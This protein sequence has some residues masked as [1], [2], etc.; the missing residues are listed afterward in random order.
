MKILIAPDSFKGS[1]TALEAAE[2]IRE[3]WM[4]QRPGDELLLAPMADGGEGTVETVLKAGGRERLTTVAGPLGQPVEALW[5][6]LA[7]GRAVIE[8]AAASGLLLVPP[9]ERNPLKTTTYG[10]GELIRAALEEGAHEI[11]LGIGGSATNDGGIGMAQALGFRFIGKD[12]SPLRRP[13]TGAG[14]HEIERIDD[15]QRLR[16]LKT[17]SIQAACDV[18]NP[19]T[20]PRGAARVYAPQKGADGQMVEN[21]DRGL[22]HLA[23]LIRRDLNVDVEEVPGAGAAGGF[24]AGLMAFCGAR[25][26]SGVDLILDAIRFDEKLENAD[27][28]LT[29][30][31]KLDQQT[32]SGKTV[33]GVVRRARRARVPVW[34]MAGVVDID[35]ESLKREGIQRVLS[36]RER[37]SEDEEAMSQA[38]RY[39][40]ELASELA[41]SM[42]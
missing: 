24:G 17:A 6:R 42:A 13:A 23:R 38:A 7:D 39:L 9:N 27:L 4:R 34:A 11:I 14:L 22:G 26:T 36:I 28:V 5:G 3:G 19:L 40:A 15:S 18:D 35:S 20:G 30:E 1:L 29:G 31:G 2:A 10:T 12:G 25:L 37:A 8:M 16:L 32:L 33:A 41:A 21:L